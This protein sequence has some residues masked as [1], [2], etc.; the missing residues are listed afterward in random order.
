MT[1]APSV[2]VLLFCGESTTS[3]AACSSAQY[4]GSR[5]GFTFIHSES[6][7]HQFCNTFKQDLFYFLLPFTSLKFTVSGMPIRHECKFLT[8][9]YLF[10]HSLCVLSMSLSACHV[11]GRVSSG[12]I[13]LTGVPIVAQWLTNPTRNHVSSIPGLAQWVKDPASP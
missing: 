7:F 5:C 10:L 13:S 1:K 8:C 9:S 2:H 6:V 12:R 11:L 4:N 3:L